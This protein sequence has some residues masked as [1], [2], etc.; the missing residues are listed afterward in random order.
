MRLPQLLGEVADVLEMDE[1][2]LCE[3]VLKESL[4]HLILAEDKEAMQMFSERLGIPLHQLVKE[5]A[6]D[7]LARCIYHGMPF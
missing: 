1:H 4:A 3:R 7:A 5:Y 2:L 6:P